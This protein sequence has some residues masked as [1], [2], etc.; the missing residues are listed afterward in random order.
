V[1]GEQHKSLVAIFRE[2]RAEGKTVSLGFEAM[3]YMTAQ[4]ASYV[5]VHDNVQML[6]LGD[7]DLILMAKTNGFHK[8]VR[9]S[10]VT[11]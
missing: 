6:Q 8:V 2:L 3:S 9:A 10:A 4:V 5:A 7:E 1:L 11:P